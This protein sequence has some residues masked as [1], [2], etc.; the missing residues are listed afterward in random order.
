LEPYEISTLFEQRQAMLQSIKEGVIA[1]D[2]SGEVTLINHAAQALLDYRKTQDD[3]RLS[4]LSHAWSQVVDISEV[5]RDGT[6]RRDEEIIVKGRLLLVNTVPVRSNG[7]IIG[8]ISTFRDKTEVRQLMQR[9]DGMVNYADALRERSHEFMNKLHV[10]LGLLHLKSYKQLE[11]YIIKTANNY[12]EEIG[13]LLGKIKSPI[14][15]GFLLSKITRASD[16]GHSLVISSD[17]QLPD[18]NNEDQVTVLITALGNLIENALEA[19]SQESGGEI[20]VSLHYRHGWLHC[21]VSD[22]GPGIE[23]ERIEAIFEKGVSSKGAERGVGL[24]LVKQQVEA[25]GGVI[26]VESEP[27]IFT[28]FFVQLPWDG[29]RT[30]L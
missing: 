18:N 26:S 8:A 27:G 7:E 2:D 19:L 30:S 12:Q 6:P 11:A 10:I 28:Q 15:A 14:I 23:P 3:A 21:E 25:L 20:S 4:T 1:V 22:D 17:S 16:F 9:L 24:A 5:L 29:K 13:L